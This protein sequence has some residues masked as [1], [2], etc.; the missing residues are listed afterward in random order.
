MQPGGEK[1]GRVGYLGEGLHCKPLGVW[2]QEQQLVERTLF[3]GTT[4][5]QGYRVSG[6][7]T[8]LNSGTCE[9]KRKWNLRLLEQQ[10]KWD[11]G[12]GGGSPGIGASEGWE[13][14][15]RS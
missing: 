11:W 9:E 8:H 5:L 13:G 4:G 14:M 6:Q 2:L 3:E 12:V 7:E 15:K 10:N 1:Q